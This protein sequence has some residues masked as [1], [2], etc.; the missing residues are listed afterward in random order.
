MNITEIQKRVDAIADAMT[1]KGVS[2][3]SAEFDIKSHRKEFAVILQWTN[4]EK[5]S[6]LDRT[7]YEFIHS[8]TPEEALDN[9]DEYVAQLPTAEETRMKQFVSALAGVIDLGREN[10]VDVE[11]I[12]PLKATMKKL[13]ENVITDQR[14]S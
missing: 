1:A 11:F 14:E 6:V 2:Q 12:N 13:S 4:V 5:T 8:P 3:A 9:A 7:C 10:G